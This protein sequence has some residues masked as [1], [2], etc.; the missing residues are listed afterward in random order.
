MKHIQNPWYFMS[1]VVVVLLSLALQGCGPSATPIPVPTPAP[2]QMQAAV[3]LPVAPTQVPTSTP[4]QAQPTAPPA[5]TPSS[6]MASANCQ[7][8][9]H[10]DCQTCH[11]DTYADWVQGPHAH[12]QADVA[13]ELSHERVG[14]TPD[15]VINGQDAEDCIACHGPRAITVNGG[16]SEAKALGYFFSTAD[17]KFGAN[18]QATNTS[19]WPQVNCTTCHDVP[20]DH[21]TGRSALGLFDS[22]T[23]KFVSQDST[24]NLCGQCHGNL[25]FA[26][27]DHRTYNAWKTSKHSTTQ[28]DVASELSDERAGQTPDQVLYGDDAEDCIACHAPTAVLANGGMDEAQ[29]LSFFFTKADGKFSAKT[30]PAH[31][32]AWPSVSC[33]ACHDQHNPGAPAYFNSTTKQYEPKSADELC[34]QCHGNLRFPGTDHLSYNIVSGKGGV[35][36]PDQQTMPG[37]GCTDCHMFVSDVD[38]SNSA[39]FHGH[40]WAIVVKEANSQ[41]TN[42]CAHCHTG[43]DTAKVESTIGNWKS[44]FQ[45]LDST[46]QGNVSKAA[47]AMEGVN[48][49]ALQFKLEEAQHNLTYAESDESGGVHN[50]NYVMALLKDANDRALEVL[51]ALKK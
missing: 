34:G 31:D 45:A 30:A 7:T 20:S 35:R 48:D 3:P 16:I 23:A 26:D 50:H 37:A 12:T 1:I 15:E 39:M 8:C 43:I 18:T 21:P 17:G 4:T 27:T 24:S 41:S 6:M 51:T 2:T 22:Q 32:W 5:V 33:T 9:H 13:D 29:A 11:Q 44:E 14:Q 10:A 40:T 38:G 36:V 46:A 28:A 25:L 47:K 19:D 49:S 42:S